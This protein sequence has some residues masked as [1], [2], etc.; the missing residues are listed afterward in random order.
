MSVD[1]LLPPLL[2]LTM[3]VEARR[4]QAVRDVPGWRL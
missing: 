3:W 2:D 1:V 4:I